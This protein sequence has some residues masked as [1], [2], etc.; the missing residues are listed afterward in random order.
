M[1]PAPHVPEQ[2]F[3]TV[4]SISDS[5][6]S[7]NSVSP[8]IANLPTET[9]PVLRKRVI[10]TPASS[11]SVT[12]TT[13][14]SSGVVVTPDSATRTLFQDADSHPKRK[15]EH[16]H[17]DAGLFDVN[18]AEIEVTAANAPSLGPCS[19]V[20]TLLP[21]IRR[22]KKPKAN[23]VPSKRKR[24]PRE[25]ARDGPKRRGAYTD[26]TK[27]RD[28]ALTRILK[29]CIR[30]RMNRS[31]CNPDPGD[32]YGPCLTC[33]SITGP[34]LCKMPCYRYI[35]TD[36]SLYREQREPW[37][38]YSRRWK[39]MDLV[40]I[41]A[42][43]WASSEI[44]RIVVSPNHLDAPFEF[45]VREFIPVEGDML[46]EQWMTATGK[47]RVAIPRYALADM[48]QTAKD[49]KHY[50]ER[51]VWKFIGVT[52]GGLD[53]LLFETYTRAFR[54]IGETNTAEEHDLLSN[55]F[56][57]WVTCR[58]ISNP[59]HIC[60][61]DKLGGHAIYS[62]DSLHNG[63]VPMP[64]VMTAQ[65]EC[66]NYTTF[67]RPLSKAV[68]KQLNELVLAKKREYWLTIY[69]SMFILLHSCA[70]MTKRDAETAA[71][72]DMGTYYAN[73]ESIRAHHSGAQTILAHFHFINKGVIPFSLPH[74]EAG[75][76]ELAK[77]ANLSNEQ[78]DFV[79]RTSNM[80]NDPERA[81]HMRY[82]RERGMVGEDLYWV[83]M[84]YDR[85]WKPTGND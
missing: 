82:A 77:A 78:V 15:R 36:A 28:T 40:D 14:S 34:T 66:I 71:Q 9:R 7:V 29:S 53:Q 31:R 2:G 59:V 23:D 27:K 73:P 45:S 84:L 72:Y 76:Q 30:C 33:K 5:I 19:K 65:F 83:S 58:L 32:P 37:Q 38:L 51:N 79:W 70:M 46:E 69:F 17:E 74:T 81:A 57:L 22:K 50:V 85:E 3:L 68:L 63:K 10:L 8:T 6:S 44:R 24:D 47:Q 42:S 61:E 75:K 55:T 52:V 12:T 1:Q 39:S 43:D 56:R 54:Y 48:N 21:R 49:M 25:V 20:W 60:G 26:E 16:S 67:L 4:S 80:V 35:V 62:P 18:Q 41:P 64:M 13:D 11:T